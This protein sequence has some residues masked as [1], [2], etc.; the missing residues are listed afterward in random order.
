MRASR[1]EEEEEEVANR[2]G[3]MPGSCAC[4]VELRF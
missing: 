2:G 4:L 3:W 1:Q